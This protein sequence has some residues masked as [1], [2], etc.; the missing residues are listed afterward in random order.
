[1]TNHNSWIEHRAVYP[2]AGFD[3]EFKYPNS[4]TIAHSIDNCLC[5]GVDTEFYNEND[6]SFED[7]TRQWCICLLDTTEY[8]VDYLISSW[9]TVFTGEVIEKRD[10]VIIGNLKAL[11]VIL[12]SKEPNASYRQLIY[13]K[14]YSTLFEVMNVDESTGKEFEV[15]CESI[16]I[17]RN[18]KP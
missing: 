4:I 1:M 11:R 17:I 10:T 8:S 3:I 18:K 13:L 14:K 5:V 16:K 7:N 6:A 2:Y 15:F 9:K 12:K